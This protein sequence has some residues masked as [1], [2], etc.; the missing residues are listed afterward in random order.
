MRFGG[1]SFR[2]AGLALVLTCPIAALAA[3]VA[4]VRQSI[5]DQ[6]FEVAPGFVVERVIPAARSDSYL[7]ITF[8]AEGHPVV[9]K[10]ND[11]PRWLLDRDGDGLYESEQ[12]ITQAVRNA[13]GLWFDGAVL[14]AV[15]TPVMS[16]EETA[17]EL[18]E[19][20]AA[21]RAA[22]PS[23]LPGGGIRRVPP[24][25][26]D[27]TAAGIFRLTDADGDGVADRS[28]PVVRLVGTMQEHGAH[29]IRRA[30]DGGWMYGAGNLAGTPPDV[31][32]VPTTRVLGD[33]EAG[34]LPPLLDAETGQRDGVHGAIYRWDAASGRFTAYAGGLRNAYDFAFNLAGELFVHDGDAEGDQGFSWYRGIRTLH[35]PL[36]ANAGHRNGSAKLPPYAPEGVAALRDLGRGSPA[37]VE[38]Y[39]ADAFPAEW[40]DAFLEAD[41]A[42]G[43]L[44]ATRLVPKGAGYEPDGEGQVLL[45]GQALPIIDVE[46][47]PDG[48]VYFTTGG[49]N[50]RGGLWRLRSMA[51]GARPRLTPVQA[52]VRQAQPLS[53]WGWAA[54]EQ[55][56]SDLGAERFA[57][58]LQALAREASVESRLRVRA[59]AEWQRH[60]RSADVTWLTP[61]AADPDA[62]VRAEVL[63]AALAV[64]PQAARRLA[65]GVLAD[66]SPL[67]RRRALEAFASVEG[68]EIPVEALWPR[69]DDDDRLVRSAARAVLE[70]LPPERWPTRFSEATSPRA[71]AE[72]MLAWARARPNDAFD[73][74]WGP[75]LAAMVRKPSTEDQLRLLRAYGVAATRVS[76]DVPLPVRRAVHAM[77]APRYPSGDPRLDRELAAVIAHARQPEAV[78]LLVAALATQPSTPAEQVERLLA[79]SVLEDGWTPALRQQVVATFATAER[80]PLGFSGKAYLTQ[81]F[82]R[83]TFRFPPEE[84]AQAH[85]AVPSLAPRAR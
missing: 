35:L 47:G 30:P 11:Y 55:V 40:A 71:L 29:A 57:Q 77:L 63:R 67:V 50:A 60:A 37:G 61:L 23:P 73:P 14:Y 69:L 49:R 82:A 3:E 58:E 52:V 56:R 18:A 83:I 80:W 74:L 17:R 6:V 46:V 19:A 38:F 10:E 78:P 66:A 27:P 81:L 84:R 51:E 53:S 13:Q 32:I 25:R 28:E 54:I 21:A 68:P 12:I 33:P 39:Q 31:A 1:S 70:G 22:G 4:L 76:T 44:R 24:P 45:R 16:R 7:V 26:G 2:G 62:A 72:V 36:G 43:T 64:D 48:A 75:W 15:A 85:A 59:I 8:D 65:G 79:L 42:R 20:A 34:I 41:W 5:G 9:S